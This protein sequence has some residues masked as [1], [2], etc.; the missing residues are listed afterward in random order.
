MSDVVTPGHLVSTAEYVRKQQFNLLVVIALFSS[1]FELE[2]DSGGVKLSMYLAAIRGRGRDAQGTATP[3][4][5]LLYATRDVTS[6]ARHGSLAVALQAKRC[7]RR[8]DLESC[9]THC[10][11]QQ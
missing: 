6:R 8:P 7:L 1:H 11:N 4:P 5:E 2:N 3:W 10:L 9:G